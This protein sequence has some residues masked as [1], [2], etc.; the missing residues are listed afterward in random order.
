M[1][2]PRYLNLE[3]CDMT[4]FIWTKKLGELDLK[5]SPKLEQESKNTCRD[6][7]KLFTYM[8]SYQ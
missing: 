6:T 7:Y 5:I 2:D 8:I 4:F 1:I 3:T